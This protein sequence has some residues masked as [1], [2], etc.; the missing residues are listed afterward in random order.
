MNTYVHTCSIRTW[1]YTYVHTCSIQ[2]WMY[3]YVHTCSVRAYQNGICSYEEEIR[4][5][6]MSST[7]LEFFYS[8]FQVKTVHIKHSPIYCVGTRLKQKKMSSLQLT[9][10][11]LVTTSTKWTSPGLH[12]V[13]SHKQYKISSLRII[14][15]ILVTDSTNWT[16]PTYCLVTNNKQYKMNSLRFT[17]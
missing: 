6:A 15:L 13:T 3:T 8:C 16:S 7:F 1:M 9:V 5:I 4:T 2:G 10:W 17:V 14:V 12:L 11:L